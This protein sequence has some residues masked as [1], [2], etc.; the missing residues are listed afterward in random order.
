MSGRKIIALLV[1]LIIVSALCAAPAFAR[2]VNFKE[3]GIVAWVFLFIGLTVILL[4]M[5]P[6]AILV[7]AF[8]GAAVTFRS[9][10]EK[11]PEPGWVLPWPKRVEEMR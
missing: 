9:R 5:I 6:A 1:T 7:F 11:T 3:A 8:I 10:R 4:Q 2:S